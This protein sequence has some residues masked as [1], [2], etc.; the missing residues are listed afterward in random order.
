MTEL[1]QVLTT[2]FVAALLSLTIAA[3]VAIPAEIFWNWL[4]PPIFGL[5]QIGY[6]QAFGLLVLSSL[7]FSERKVDVKMHD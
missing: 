3:V 1:L 4:M 6:T 7:F 5:P 2:W